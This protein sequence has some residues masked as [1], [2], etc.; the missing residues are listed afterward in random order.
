MYLHQRDQSDTVQI[1]TPEF[2]PDI[3]GDSQPNTDKGCE[4]VPVQRH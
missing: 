1:D 3:D 2:E 4:T